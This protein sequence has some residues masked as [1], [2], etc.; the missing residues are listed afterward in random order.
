MTESQFKIERDRLLEEVKHAKP[1]NDALTL[2]RKLRAEFDSAIPDYR[3]SLA[4][5]GDTTYEDRKHFLLELIQ[6]ADDAY[7]DEE[8]TLISFS[9]Y[10]DS[11]EISYNEKGF[12]INDV[13]A[14]TGTGASTKTANKLS[15]NSFIGE[16]GIG[17]KSVFA[18]ANEVRIESG[19]WGFRLHKDN[20]IVPELIYPV[21]NSMKGTKLRVYFSS[22]ESVTIVANELL[23]L[24]TK[25]LESFLFLQRLKTFQYQDF[26]QSVIEP[27]KL[28][29]LP[30]GENDRLT[31]ETNPGGLTRNYSLYEEE[32]EFPGELVGI[33]WERLGSQHSLKRKISIAAM[34]NSSYNESSLGR[35][36][37]YLPTEV[38]LPIP[39]FLQI[40]GHL[41]A[42]RERL[43]DIENNQ[44]N[45]YL[46]KKIPSFILRTILKWR[47]NE[48]LSS[49]LPNFV[50]DQTGEDQLKPVF[51]ALIEKCRYA[52]WVK[53]F[54]GWSVPEQTVMAESFWY[55]WFEEYPAFRIQM[56]NV[57]G[58]KLMHPDWIANGSWTSKWRKYSISYLNAKEITKVLR[59]VALP[60]G[61]LEN[62]ENIT[63]LYRSLVK[64]AEAL[65]FYHKKEFIQELFFTKVFPLE[66]GEFGALK[67]PSNETDKIYW[68]SGRTKRTSGLEGIIDI[69]IINPE[70]TYA[71]QIGSESSVER[72]Q[73]AKEI[74][75]RNEQVRSLLKYME[76]AEFNDNRLLSDLQIPF[77]LKEKENW[78][79]EDVQLRYQVLRSIFEVYQ[80]K[81]TLDETYVQQLGKL[82]DALMLGTNGK[83]K[84]L[85][86][87]ILPENLRLLKEDHL[88]SNAGL[89]SL[90]LSDEWLEPELKMENQEERQEIYL[91][92]LRAFL[93][94]CGVANGPKFFFK[95]QKYSGVW[96][97]ATQEKDLHR[98]WKNRIGND[99][100]SGNRITLKSVTLDSATLQLID[101]GTIS[102]EI[103]K[104]IYEEW[105]KAFSRNLDRLDS[106]YYRFDPPPGYVQTLYKRRD[107]RSPIIIDNHWAGVQPEQIPLLTAD[108]RLTNSK[109]AFKIKNTKGLDKALSYFDF[110]VE[111]ETVGHHPFYLNSL[112]L[113]P[114]TI[115]EINQA[116]KNCDSNSY[117]DL[118]QAI[119]ELTSMDI[120]FSELIIYDVVTKVLRPVQH[121]KLGKPVSETTPYIEEQYGTYGKLLGQKLGLL[122]ES[123]VT[124]LFQILD[125]FYLQPQ[126]RDWVQENM[127]RLLKQSHVLRVEDKSKLIR[128]IAE[129]RT[130]NKLEHDTLVLF[131]EMDL[132]Q[133][134]YQTNKFVIHLA[135]NPKELFLLKQA[136][137][138]IGFVSIEDV[139][140]ISATDALGFE[141]KGGALLDSMFDMYNKELEEMESARFYGVLAKVG[142]KANFH[143]VIYRTE[144]LSKRVFGISIPVPLP[145]YDTL[146]N[147]FFVSG[148]DSLPEI[149]ARLLS[150]FGFTTYR[151]AIRDFREIFAK[152]NQNSVEKDKPQL[153]NVKKSNLIADVIAEYD[154]NNVV[155]DDV[156][157][158]TREQNDLV[159]QSHFVPQSS[160]ATNET[161]SNRF[162]GNKKETAAEKDA[163]KS[164]LKKHPSENYTAANPVTTGQKDA[165]A[166]ASEKEADPNN[167]QTTNEK[168]KEKP[169]QKVTLEDILQQLSEQM[170]QDVIKN[171]E[172][173]ND[174]KTA[175]DPEEGETIRSS[176][177]D[178]LEA[179]LE[180]G[181]TY[182]E[183]K[184]RKKKQKKKV[185][186]EDVQHPKEF[187]MHEYDGRCQ[188]CETQLKMANGKP[189]FEVFRIKESKDGAWWTNRPFN[190]LC[191]CPNCHA[192]AKYGG[193]LDFSS[194]MQEATLLN[195]QQT[196]AQ[197]VEAYKGDYYV[198]EI[199][200]NGET[201]HLA[202]SSLHME[203]F[204]ALVHYVKENELVEEVR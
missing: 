165:E 57:L 155:K 55:K 75:D 179:S 60:G 58:K 143:E 37:C 154:L 138:D 170:I 126:T 167:I 123:E 28:S 4:I 32:I 152:L 9:I 135:C 185:I 120:D 12:T 42:D 46:L 107:N 188:I 132:Y 160:A 130:E 17:F 117:Q 174:W 105:F 128:H 164:L 114:I 198:I 65:R 78:T 21:D 31:L 15:A 73:E 63:L 190:T 168:A 56:E 144:K 162:S 29:I 156:E 124:P 121:F 33:R 62:D 106:L 189:Y 150:S 184:D 131:N 69:K 116:W 54:D 13:I 196:F 113:K 59:Y 43:H 45:K 119:Y 86:Q 82:A 200:H 44:W 161:D 181:P 41:K 26:R 96:E 133:K 136:A 147:Q 66:S 109:T 88:Y 203:Y 48:E 153:E 52:P 64:H 76:I 146:K 110:V 182:Q 204:A 87:M 35:L 24:V 104:G 5:L 100:T 173:Q 127:T 93:L 151:S 137:K 125:S 19:P 71:L 81:T 77:L 27:K 3:N 61:L 34:T 186:D 192:L 47:E 140:T 99:Y 79:T 85:Y 94:H 38:K 201:K 7:Y 149:A 18:L 8:E 180:E 159:Q 169:N 166:N 25:Q 202:I 11:L 129:L 68:M 70:Y 195:Q 191:L 22:S 102:Q 194:I 89:D 134:L 172:K 74:N 91:K 145:Y 176:V 67:T 80:P 97:F 158:A 1:G 148:E 178:N 98:N 83:L 51:G 193:P 171:E 50:P 16:K 142:G 10:E 111:E 2:L 103:A 177:R 112:Q 118:L 122:V 141:D 49:L 92:K 6:N 23:K 39:V 14:I 95:E 108:G 199:T 163:V 90:Y 187:L 183:V 115:Q 72:K 20:Y 53:T 139:G 84:K 36:F 101:R 30:N 157:I 197:E 40:D 175:L